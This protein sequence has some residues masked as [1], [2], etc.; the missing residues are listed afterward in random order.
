MFFIIIYYYFQGNLTDYLSGL[1]ISGGVDSMALA[2]LCAKL[3][4]HP[5]K[6]VSDF[7]NINFQAFVVDHGVRSES[8][9]EAFSVSKILEKQGL[10]FHFDMNRAQS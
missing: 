6:G 2:A 4:N 3:Q 7:P 8:S 9:L 10:L 5:K 1:A